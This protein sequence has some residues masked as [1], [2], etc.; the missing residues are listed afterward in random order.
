MDNRDNMF[1]ISPGD[2][3]Q[4][5][6]TCSNQMLAGCFLVVTEPKCFGC[7]GYVQMAGLNEEI[8]GQ[9]YCRLNWS[10]VRPTGGKAVWATYHG[11]ACVDRQTAEASAPREYS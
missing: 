9:V 11:R 7:Q 5:S 10:E 3:L 8:G 6:P 2:I 4:I 1:P